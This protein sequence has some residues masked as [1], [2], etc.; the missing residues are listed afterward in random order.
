MKNINHVMKCLCLIFIVASLA[1]GCNTDTKNK[2]AEIN[3]K[4][5]YFEKKF[6]VIEEKIV[7]FNP[8]LLPFDFA[9]SKWESLCSEYDSLS[10]EFDLFYADMS[11]VEDMFSKNP[12]VTKEQHDRIRSLVDRMIQVLKELETVTLELQLTANMMQLLGY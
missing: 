2:R 7:S 9:M 12:I 11:D 5:E 6:D 4:I 3:K 1:S 8:T 10:G